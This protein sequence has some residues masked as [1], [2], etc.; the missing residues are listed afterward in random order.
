[1][2]RSLTIHRAGPSLTVQDAGRPGY[3]GQGLSRSGAADP[4]A[5]AEGAAL[6]GQSAELAALEMAGVGGEFTADQDTRIALTGAPMMATLDGAP[7]RWNASHLMPRGARLVIGAAGQGVYGYLHLGGGLATPPL[8]GSRSVHLAA[9]VGRACVTGDDLPI[10]PDRGKTTGLTLDPEPRLTGGAL[11]IVPSMQTELFPPAERARFEAA[12]FTRDTRANRMG[13]RMLQPGAPFAAQGQ[14]N[15]LSEIIVPGDIQMTG[16]GTPFVLLNECQTT[17]GYPR[18]G[19]VIAPDL[20]RV[21]QAGPGTKLRFQF[22]T[23]ETALD[24]LRRYRAML[25]GLK[26]RTRPLVR[27]PHDIPDLLSY[28]LVDGAISAHHEGD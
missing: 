9:G 1:M 17:G 21:A 26:S 3:L 10:G 5:L 27:A 16:E 23:Q 2:T 15:I 14:L 7:L 19:T 12:E 25:A 20:P 11:R 22:V 8:L 13:V 24:A 4:I 6:L 28:Q 18:I